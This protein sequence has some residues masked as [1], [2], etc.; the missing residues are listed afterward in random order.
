MNQAV[1]ISDQDETRYAELQH[2]ALDFARKGEVESL[3]GMLDAGMPVNLSD[4]K[5][6]SLL[7]LAAYNGRYATTASLIARGAEIDRRNDRGQTPL[8]GVS[9]KGE[10]EIARLLLEKGAEPDAD[11]GG[12]QTPLMF[13]SMFGRADV[14]ELL[15]QA[16]ADAKKRN[17]LGLNAGQLRAFSLVLKPLAS[18]MKRLC[19]KGRR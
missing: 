4:A 5:G 17:R 10:L 7:M 19:A 14:A 13:A 11:Q 8:G 1:S 2:L 12:G 3:E 6:N 18:W 16:G 15:R 9:F